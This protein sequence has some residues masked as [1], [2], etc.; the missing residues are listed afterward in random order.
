MI[1]TQQ[2]NLPK[3]IFTNQWKDNYA[4]TAQLRNMDYADK[5]R[6]KSVC[7]CTTRKYEQP[8]V[9]PLKICSYNLR[10]FASGQYY[11]QHLLNETDICLV[12]EY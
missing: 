1:T 4:T 2:P 10:G 5:R 6:P 11:L 12:Q 8:T 7:V 3:S 9:T